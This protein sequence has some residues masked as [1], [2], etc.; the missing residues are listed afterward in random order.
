MVISQSWQDNRVIAHRGA[1]KEGSLPQNSIASMKATFQGGYHAT[2]FDV[3][4]TADDELVIIHDPSHAGFEIEKITYDDLKKHTLA[5]GEV[6][7]TLKTYLKTGKKQ[8]KS[9]LILEIKISPAGK[10]RSL[11]MADRTVEMVKK[12]KAQKWVTYISFDKDILLQILKNDPKADTQYLTGD[13][14]PAQLK[15]LGITG[16]DYHYF[17][18]QKYPNW[19]DECQKLGIKTNVWTVNDE[20]T[21]RYF[22]LRGIDHIT[23]DEP[24]LALAIA[25]EI[26][27][28]RR[29]LAWS[30]EFMYSGL[31]DSTIW[32]YDVG[33]HGWGNQE[34]QYYTD[35]DSKNVNVSN[36]TLK[37]TARKTPFEDKDYTSA[38]LITRGLKDVHHGRVDVRAK[39][40]QGRGIWPAIWTLGQNRKEAGWPACGEIDIMEHVG[41][42]ADTIHASTHSVEHNHIKKT[43]KTNQVKI[44]DPY[45]AYHVYSVEYS[46]EKMTFL[47]DDKPYYTI[48]RSEC[49]DWPFDHPHYLILNIAVGGFWGAAKG[50][51]DSIWPQTM[52]VDYVRVWK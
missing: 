9:R 4:M 28:K 24:K 13:L 51:D 21:M 3:R 42:D 6:I 29:E 31:P 18:F 27:N 16:M 39:L 23:T 41:Y 11:L 8:K 40:P 43:Q 15:E 38:R 36:G 10:E 48:L 44:E 14:S 30:D 32:T 2:E 5:N 1:W 22:F 26:G 25:K 35:A 17:A 47:L 19:I 49:K 50:M 33:G 34:L 52:E 46:P 20:L 37:I 45:N 7:P 12:L